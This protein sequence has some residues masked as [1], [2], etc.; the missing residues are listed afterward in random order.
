MITRAATFCPAKFSCN[1]SLQPPHRVQLRL[2]RVEAFDQQHRNGDRGRNSTEI[3]RF[4]AA[5]D[6]KNPA[7]RIHEPSVAARLFG[8]RNNR[9]G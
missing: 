5:L 3:N 6:C 9:F 2:V 7:H 4:H 1:P 8:R